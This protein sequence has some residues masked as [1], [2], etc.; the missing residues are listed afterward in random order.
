MNYK[1]CQKTMEQEY[2]YMVS[3]LCKTFNH[4]PYIEDTLEGFALQQTTFPCV[5]IVIDDASTDGEPDVLR[6]W[7]KQRLLLDN[8][9]TH[10]FF[11]YGERYSAYLKSNPLFLFV[12]VLLNENHHRKKPKMPY[13]AEWRNNA[14]YHALCEGDDYWIEPNKL[15]NQVSYLESHPTCVMSHTAIRYYFEEEKVFVDS[16]DVEINSKII[17]EGLTPERLL[18]GYRIQPCTVVYRPDALARAKRADP[19]LFKS[20]FK[21]GDTQLWYQLKKEGNICFYP[22]VCAVYRKHTGSAT[23]EKRFYDRLLFSLSSAELR[24]YLAQRDGLSADFCNS[25]K[26][27]YSKSYI[28]C[29]AFDKGL[30]AK[31]PVNLKADKLL[32][33]LYKAHLLKLWLRLYMSVDP[34]L[35]SIKRRIEGKM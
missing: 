10:Q 15:Q 34:W 30:I 2:K 13:V 8:D 25:I 23:M 33:M 28:S 4:A 29:L 18:R 21:M 9:S 35:S 11:P 7:A 16:K 3:T 26:R 27:W 12:L 20:N 31:Y 6:R 24:M 22:K 14:K 17:N 32:Y 5:F 19:Y 1:N